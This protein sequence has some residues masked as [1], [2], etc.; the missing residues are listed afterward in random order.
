MRRLGAFLFWFKF[1]NYIIFFFLEGGGQ[2]YL[3]FW[4]MKILWVLLGSHDK[5]G[6]VVGVSSMYFRVLNEQNENIF[7]WQ[8]LQIFFGVLDIP[9][10]FL[11][12]NGI[13]WAQSYV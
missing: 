13:C 12:A 4:G 10:I 2:K 1:L 6:L 5:I 8:N 7:A 3:Y 9:D 11:A